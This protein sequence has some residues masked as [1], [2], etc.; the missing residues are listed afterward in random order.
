VCGRNVNSAPAKGEALISERDEC[1]A[2]V[3]A[4][5]HQLL[6]AGKQCLR[7][8][9]RLSCLGRFFGILKLVRAPQR[10]GSVLGVEDFRIGEGGF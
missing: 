10:T 1:P 8:T 5:S 7:R 9:L 4:L 3:M 6:G 2:R